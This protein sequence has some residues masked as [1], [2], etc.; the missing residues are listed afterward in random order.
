MKKTNLQII[1]FINFA[2]FYLK[3]HTEPTKFRYALER[4]EKRAAKVHELFIEKLADINI[5]HAATDKDGALLTDQNDGFRFTKEGIRAR[6]KAR[7][8][9]LEAAVELEPYI[10]TEMPKAELIEAEKEVCAGF[11][12]EESKVE[13]VAREG[14]G[15]QQPQE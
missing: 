11:V 9:L 10:A 2:R 6:N 1:N 7:K 13:A 8:E 4:M 15:A 3:E 14:D 12:I 5:E